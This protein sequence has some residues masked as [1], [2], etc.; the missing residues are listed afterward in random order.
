MEKLQE[1]QAANPKPPMV[2]SLDSDQGQLFSDEEQCDDNEEGR[3][4]RAVEGQGE[5][6]GPALSKLMN[7]HLL[8]LHK[9]EKSNADLCALIVILRARI[10][11]LELRLGLQGQ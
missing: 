4:E 1:L 9:A 8:W 11:C 3:R 5:E 2:S 6:T 7:K 10:R